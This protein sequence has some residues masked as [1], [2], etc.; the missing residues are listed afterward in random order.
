MP[1]PPLFS[2]IT[3]DIVTLNSF[4][5]DSFEQAKLLYRASENE[6]LVSNFHDK[7]DGHRFTL[8][9]VLTEF[10]KVIGGFTP[11]PWK[12]GGGEWYGDS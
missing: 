5:Q 8:T 4:F 7:C 9:L 3:N 11:L 12:S 1:K 6:Y 10:D 2:K